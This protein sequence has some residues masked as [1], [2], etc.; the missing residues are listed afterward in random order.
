MVFNKD[1]LFPIVGA[2]MNSFIGSRVEDNKRKRRD[3]GRNY[4]TY[5][6]NKPLF[7]FV[8]QSGIVVI[9]CHDG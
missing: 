5:L 8:I 4:S 6:I 1:S 2:Y 7:A 9:A 3:Q